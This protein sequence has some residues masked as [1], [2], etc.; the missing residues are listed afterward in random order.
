MKFTKLILP[1]LLA[2]GI[3]SC[4]I[5]VKTVESISVEVDQKTRVTGDNLDTN[6]FKV[7]LNY[8][9][10]TKT[11]D[12]A[13]F[14]SNHLSAT[15]YYPNDLG[16]EAIKDN[17]VILQHEGLY[18]ISVDYN[19]ESKYQYALNAKDTFTVEKKI[20]PATSFSIATTSLSLSKGLSSAL[21]YTV[22]PINC[23]SDV[24]FES[25]DINV[26]TV[27]ENGVVTAIE[28]GQCM[29]YAS[30]DN[31]KKECLI[32]VTPTQ[33]VDYVF[34][35]AQFE[36]ENGAWTYSK[37]GVSMDSKNN[38]GVNINEE[39]TLTSPVSFDSITNIEIE[40]Y[41]SGLLSSNSAGDI[42]TYVGDQLIGT[43]S[44]NAASQS[45][46]PSYKVN[47]LSGEVK[48]VVSPTTRIYMRSVTVCYDSDS[49]YPTSISLDGPTQLGV[50]NSDKMTISYTPANANKRVI[51]WSSSNENILRVA[52]DGSIY[53]LSEGTANVTAKAQTES[54]F[55]SDSVSIHVVRI[56]VES[57]S[58]DTPTL[59]IYIGNSKTISYSIL[60]TNAS[61][62][63]VSFLSA[64][65]SVATVDATGNVTG[66]AIGECVVYVIS[67]DDPDVVSNCKV[68]VS[69][70]PA[71]TAKKM[72]YNANDY[73]SHNF[74]EIDS[75]P[76]L[77]K[78]KLLVIP[79][80]FKDSSTFITNKDNVRNDIKSVYF[81]SQEATGWNSVKTYYETESNG[82][83]TL[84]GTVSEWYETS[85]S[86]SSFNYDSS[87]NNNTT[88]NLVKTATDWYFTN[89]TSDNRKNY[90][91]DGD[92]YLDG[93]I[94]IYGCPDY[95]AFE[96]NSKFSRVTYGD[97]LWA[98]TY[99][100]QNKNYKS[101][102]N[103]GVNAYFWA[104]YDF[105]YSSGLTA[106]SRTGKSSYG[107]GI[108][109]HSTL[110]SHT[111]IHEM[112]HIFGL[113]D[114]YDYSN[115]YCP[116]G[117]FSM[118]DYNVGGHDPFSCLS[119]G[120]A[121]AFIPYEDCE[122]T[123]YPFQSSH[124][125]ILLSPS[126]NS[127]NSPFDEYMLLE[128]YTPTGLN[129]FDTDYAYG[130]SSP[131]G[132]NASGIRLWHVD[133]RLVKLNNLG[134]GNP[135]NVYTYPVD[136]CK[137]M[138]SNT[139]YSSST[140]GYISP[141]GR[142]YADYNLLQLIRNN[143]SATYTQTDMFKDA[144]L[145]KNGSSFK[146]ETYRKQFVNSGKLNSG[147]ELGWTF[148]VS[149][150]GTGENAVATVTLNRL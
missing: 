10:S 133:A 18:E 147:I 124:Q 126:F 114:Y 58:L 33:S 27:N 45:F 131:R 112:G 1:C 25:S 11:V 39:T 64:N 29:I 144:S 140:S 113:D 100:V 31:F 145:F 16:Y 104:S 141:C 79:V 38:R 80:Y 78:T 41:S 88:T 116:A 59:E 62:Q 40:C 26:A 36:T 22:N 87:D 111:F 30:V 109:S 86:Y 60:P 14:S 13:N 37:E 134:N 7:I 54:G 51:E 149:M 129:K 76:S 69:E 24:I 34:K 107:S 150:T 50:N 81:G 99:W 98:Y 130:T 21:E 4:S 117:G 74:Y 121:D 82:R 105:M 101:V 148:S 125:V 17:S 46:K 47:N 137:F 65:P 49:I 128:L 123:L 96:S 61:N 20:V 110:D 42:S 71:L 15:L 106:T 138:M 120:W 72:S 70:K 122:I 23:T 89:H 93:V 132:V 143:T 2:L 119:L 68:V 75:A 127:Y 85:M 142:S 3:A 44:L 115:S 6:D 43:F 35:N 135:S 19:P 55:V 146:M 57:I 118:Q 56:P 73:T 63:N 8:G 108:T 91:C 90:D 84:E 48:F 52:R 67:N 12:F 9:D 28:E 103:P 83:L 94:L 92:G 32:T 5:K 95:S 53:G 136:N 77:D 97:N 139:Y 66:M 102:T